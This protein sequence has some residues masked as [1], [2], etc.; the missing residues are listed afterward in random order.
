MWDQLLKGLER[1]HSTMGVGVA[2]AATAAMEKHAA[3]VG[4]LVKPGVNVTTSA[5][6]HSLLCPETL[7]RV[8]TWLEEQEIEAA[9]KALA[10]R[11]DSVTCGTPSSR[12]CAALGQTRAS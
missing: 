3:V 6:A 12:W 8:E 7:K 2:P 4:R 11:L 1:A 9:R 10:A 5:L